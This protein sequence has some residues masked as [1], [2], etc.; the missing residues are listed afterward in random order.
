MIVKI[1]LVGLL[2]IVSLA[3]WSFAQETKP[4]SELSDEE[5]AVLAP[6]TFE[7]AELRKEISGYTQDTFE[8]YMAACD[9]DHAVGCQIAGFILFFSNDVARDPQRGLELYERGCRLGE[10]NACIAAGHVHEVGDGVP[11]DEQQAVE[12]FKMACDLGSKLM[13]KS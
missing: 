12:F 4:P 3:G 6:I 10:A 9:Y 13:C 2:S 11:A 5:K 8:I 7:I 1:W